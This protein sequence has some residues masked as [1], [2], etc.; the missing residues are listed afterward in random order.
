MPMQQLEV[1]FLA[2]FRG[3]SDKKVVFGRRCKAAQGYYLFPHRKNTE[4]PM[5]K[6][7]DAREVAL[8]KTGMRRFRT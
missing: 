3:P 6:A 7:N 2:F 5:L 8:R 1:A 4:R